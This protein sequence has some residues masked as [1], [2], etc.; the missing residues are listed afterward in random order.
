[1]SLFDS[2]G[3]Y[4]N[5]DEPTPFLNHKSVIYGFIITFLVSKQ[6]ET[7]TTQVRTARR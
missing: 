4:D 6:N 2:L 1:M 3:A 7:F 5:L